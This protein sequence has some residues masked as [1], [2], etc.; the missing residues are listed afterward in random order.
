MFRHEELYK[1]Q[2]REEGSLANVVRQLTEM[3]KQYKSMKESHKE[4]EKE[5]SACTHRLAA[6][7]K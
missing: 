5:H 7:Q 4:M 2:E 6:L 1:S 3:I